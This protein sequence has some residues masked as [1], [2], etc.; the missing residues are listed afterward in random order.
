M[1]EQGAWSMEHGALEQCKVESRK[2]KAEIL[3][4]LIFAFYFLNFRANFEL[5]ITK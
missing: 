5:R 4:F 1:F 3:I 2:L